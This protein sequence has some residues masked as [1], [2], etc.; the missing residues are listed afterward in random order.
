MAQH[1]CDL[2][3]VHWRYEPEVVQS[4]LPRELSVDTFDGSAWVGLIPFSMRGIGLAR[5]P[6]V[7]YFGT[8]S[9]VNVR[10]YV[11]HGDRSGVWFFSLD[12]DRLVPALV[13][14]AGYRLPYCWGATFH[15]RDGDRL[16]TVVNRRWPDRVD[17]ARVEVERAE[18]VTATE[19][20]VF[21]TARWGLFS[22]TRRGMRYAA[23][24]HGSWP[25]RKARL[26]DVAADSL[27]EASGLPRPRGEVHVRCSD[28]VAVRIGKPRRVSSSQ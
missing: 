15:H 9:E 8:F 3:Y 1:W 19:L 10:T 25:L 21:L 28:G 23:V 17:T 4:L 18:P 24:D 22:P 26:V 13:A 20:D 6:G 16:T 27:I 5:G 7:P 14:R 11:R 2:A 12:V